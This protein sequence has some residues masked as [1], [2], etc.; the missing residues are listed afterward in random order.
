LIK[1]KIDGLFKVLFPP[2]LA[3][4]K[5]LNLA[6]ID[7]NL[8]VLSGKNVTKIHKNVFKTGSDAKKGFVLALQG[9][10]QT[11]N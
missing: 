8:Q 11:L 9:C 4:R 10:L 5:K 7:S 6:L 3:S 1:L 2:K